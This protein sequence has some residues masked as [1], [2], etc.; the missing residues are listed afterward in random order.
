MQMGTQM[1]TAVVTS[2][3]ACPDCGAAMEP[4]AIVPTSRHSSRWWHCTNG[5]CRAEWLVPMFGAERE[6]ADLAWTF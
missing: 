2:L 5:K 3:K 6:T 4:Q 1:T